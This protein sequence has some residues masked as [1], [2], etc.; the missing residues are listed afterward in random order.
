MNLLVNCSLPE[1]SSNT[2]VET[3][4]V[5]QGQPGLVNHVGNG[6]LAPRRARRHPSVLPADLE[7]PLPDFSVG[8]GGAQGKELGR[9]QRPPTRVRQERGALRVR[10]DHRRLRGRGEM[11]S[12]EAQSR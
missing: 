5:P 1:P 2:P 6:S 3:P 12:P 10:A 11:K 4:W 8:I 9:R 7:P